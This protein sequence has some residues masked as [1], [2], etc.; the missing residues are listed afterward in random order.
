MTKTGYLNFAR[1]ITG[2]CRIAHIPVLHVQRGKSVIRKRAMYHSLLFLKTKGVA[3]LTLTKQT[4][5]NFQV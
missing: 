4:Q 2:F 3:G 1:I 5:E